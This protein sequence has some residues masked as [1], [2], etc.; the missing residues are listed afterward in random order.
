[1]SEPGSEILIRLID[2][3]C[4]E[5]AARPCFLF[6]DRS[7]SYAEVKA[8]SCRIAGG[9]VALGL[10]PG[11]RGAVLSPNDPWAFAVTLGIIRAGA[12]WFPVNPRNSLDDNL[13]L[14]RQVGC[15]F[16]AYHSWYAASA[17]RIQAALPGLRGSICL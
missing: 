14:L 8:A 11:M 16:L 9:L 12:I 5:H 7:L 3:A 13:A 10:S 6:G 4:D 17:R 2:A 15:D 1:M